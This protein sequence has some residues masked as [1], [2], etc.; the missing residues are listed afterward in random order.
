MQLDCGLNSFAL[1]WAHQ[2]HQKVHGNLWSKAMEGLF[3]PYNGPRP[4][5]LGVFLNI[6]CLVIDPGLVTIKSLTHICDV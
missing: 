4:L 3:W 5:I 2:A 6:S 1:E